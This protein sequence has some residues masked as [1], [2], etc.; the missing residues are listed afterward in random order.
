[1]AAKRQ[2]A[3]FRET[4]AQA[5]ATKRQCSDVRAKE[6]QAMAAKR[7][8]ADFREMEAQVKA[9]KR[10][11][12]EVRAKESQAMVAKRQ[13]AD[14]RE[15]ERK[16]KPKPLNASVLNSEKKKHKEAMPDQTGLYSLKYHTRYTL[17]AS[18]CLAQNIA[19]LNYDSLN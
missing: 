19:I 6:S 10:Q 7:Q 2:C 15:M 4:E 3:D 8:C 9:T 1:M 16:L 18:E 17:S 11:C 13:C 14:I 5:K 12:A